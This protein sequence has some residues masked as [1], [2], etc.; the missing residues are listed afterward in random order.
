MQCGPLS[1]VVDFSE[2]IGAESDYTPKIE[3]VPGDM[4]YKCEN[5]NKILRYVSICFKGPKRAIQHRFRTGNFCRFCLTLSQF[6]NA[7]T[8]WILGVSLCMSTRL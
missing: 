7:I 6:G 4:F 5:L 8:S 1:S 3:V 2:L